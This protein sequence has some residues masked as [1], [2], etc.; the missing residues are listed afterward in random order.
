MSFSN[1]LASAGKAAVLRNITQVVSLFIDLQANNES[2]EERG[3]GG[4]KGRKRGGGGEEERG[5]V[6]HPD[7]AEWDDGVF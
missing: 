3:G 4:K 2:E 1:G 5:W 7:Y 6:S